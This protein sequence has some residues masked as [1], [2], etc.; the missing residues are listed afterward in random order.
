MKTVN[1][2]TRGINKKDEKAWKLL[3][4]SFYIPLCR[5]S[6]RIVQDDDAAKDVVQETFIRLWNNDVIFENN[7]GMIAYLYRAVSNNSLKYLRD[8]NTEEEQL[9]KWQEE[10]ELSEEYF[11]SVVREE[12][13]RKL[14]DLLNRLPEER[15]K[16]MLLSLKGMSGK[17]IAQ[18]LGITIHTVKQQKYRAYKFIH[19]NLDKNWFILFVILTS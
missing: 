19:A 4:D 7:K 9:K 15:R 2:L 8:K 12:V 6:L 18:T 10:N 11:S 5:H 13:Y 1:D 14:G 17:E 3:F 16:I